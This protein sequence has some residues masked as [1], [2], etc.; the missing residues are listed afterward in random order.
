MR[1]APYPY[2]RWPKL[3]RSA[4][5]VATGLARIALHAEGG[6]GARITAEAASAL[7]TDF[8]VAPGPARMWSRAELAAALRE[9]LAAVV[10]ALRQDGVDHC[11]VLELTSDLGGALAERVLGGDG[12]SV[13]APG[14]PLDELELGALGY[15]AARVAATTG[16]KLR[17]C[18]VTGRR[19]ALLEAL[20][21][22]GDELVVWPLE[23]SAG[24]RRGAARVLMPVRAA[25]AWLAQTP[26]P[27]RFDVPSALLG[28][29]VQL[30]AHAATVRLTARE[31]A[32]LEPGDIVVPE[33]TS[34]ARG[35]DGFHGT[36]TLHALGAQSRVHARCGVTAREL[37]I[38]AIEQG[39]YAMNDD[40]PGALVKDAPIELCVELARFKVRLEDVLGLRVGEVWSTGNA[41]GE[42][43]TLTANGRPIAHGE[44][45]DIDGEV[46]VRILEKH[47]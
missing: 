39:E 3:S 35:A 26:R 42:R 24:E 20:A 12:T 32:V 19:S 37:R 15:L 4:A 45:V 31:L 9:P 36:A 25:A 14:L 21:E 43:V 34:L 8:H 7:G 41:I 38:E 5:Q 22:A 28:L 47:G 44:L 23:L 29:P 16:S 40:E 18:E 2:E 1:G 11:V 17:V 30:C 46:G 13:R 27:R 6:A 33:R 10:S